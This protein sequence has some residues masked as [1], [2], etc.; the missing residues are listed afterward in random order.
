[1]KHWGSAL[2]PLTILLALTGL[3]FW[4]RYASEMPEPRR[5]GKHRHDPDYIVTDSTLRKLDK[6]G[7]LQYTLK[8]AEIRHY[9]DDDSTDVIKPNLIYLHA[10]KPPVTLT[11]D[12]GHVSKDGEQVDL[13]DNVRIN[14]A[15]S[16]KEEALTA[17]T[18]ELTVLPDDEKAFT[19]SAVLITKGKSWLKGVGLQVDNRAQTYILESKASAVLESKHAKKS[20]P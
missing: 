1:M 11:A 5:D 9:P 19:R 2:F 6:T 4:L 15:K 18:S 3:T 7:R 16:A 20:K 14:R 17:T 8:A 12:R 13:Y 10:K